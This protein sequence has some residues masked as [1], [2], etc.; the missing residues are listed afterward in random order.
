LRRYDVISIS[1][2]DPFNSI[3]IITPGPWV[4]E[5]VSNRVLYRDGVPVAVQQGKEVRL[6][7]EIEFG[8]E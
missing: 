4:P 2:A 5:L 3:G 7:S 8:K 1:A 6:L